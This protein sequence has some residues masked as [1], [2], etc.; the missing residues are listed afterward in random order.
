[1]YQ[2]IM[3]EEE[4]KHVML[5]VDLFT[6]PCFAVITQTS[7]LCSQSSQPVLLYTPR[8]SVSAC[9]EGR[10]CTPCDHGTHLTSGNILFTCEALHG[11][12][13]RLVSPSILLWCFILMALKEVLVKV[14]ERTERLMYTVTF[15]NC[16]LFESNK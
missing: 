16:G 11:R 1:M 7:L 13:S 12:P 3:A 15:S 2:Y 9:R 10:G 8:S 6:H 4:D 5:F 14:K